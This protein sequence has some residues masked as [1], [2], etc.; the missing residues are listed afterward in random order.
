VELGDHISIEMDAD[1]PYIHYDEHK[2]KY[3]PGKFK[4][5]GK[6]KIIK[7]E[8]TMLGKWAWSKL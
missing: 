5:K 3:P 4:K 2:H 1:K 6:K 7:H 8:Y